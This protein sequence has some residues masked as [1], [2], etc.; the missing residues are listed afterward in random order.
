MWYEEAAAYS[1]DV[2]AVAMLYSAAFL[3]RSHIE[4]GS[5]LWSFYPPPAGLMDL[6]TAIRV[7]QHETGTA[8]PG[9][10]DPRDEWRQLERRMELIFYPC[11]WLDQKISGREYLPR[12][13][14]SVCFN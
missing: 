9:D 4:G 7:Y 6:D 8:P 11:I 1:L 2:P 10:P 3:R 5:R 14:G 13:R 12:I